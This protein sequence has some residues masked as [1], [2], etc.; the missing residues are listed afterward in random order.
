M[1]KSSLEGA[2]GNGSIP[3]VASL[4]PQ[5]KSDLARLVA[6]P[7]ISAPNFPES[8]HAPLLAARD[9]VVD[10]CRAA[11]VQNLGSLDLPN[12]AP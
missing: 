3:T 7:S 9:A 11:G 6:I 10:L 8:T 2:A 1:T 4:M 5:L 12:T